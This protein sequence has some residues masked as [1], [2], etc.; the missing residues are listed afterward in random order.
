MLA[1]WRKES[2]D[3]TA[4]LICTLALIHRDPKGSSSPTVEQFNPYRRGESTG[5]GNGVPLTKSFIRAQYE[6]YLARQ[7]KANVIGT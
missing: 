5:S 6:A 2:W 7:A 4:A 1:A 3:Q